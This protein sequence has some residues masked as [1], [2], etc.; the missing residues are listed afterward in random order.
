MSRHGIT[1]PAIVL[2]LALTATFAISCRASE[3]LQRGDYNEF[4]NGRD[5]DCREGLIC[6]EGVC[7]AGGPAADFSCEEICQ[8]MTDCD[9]GTPTCV[10]DCLTTMGSWSLQAKNEFAHCAVEDLSCAEAQE[11]FAQ[12]CYS[13]I[14][15]PD[16]RENT[17]DFFTETANNCSPGVNTESLGQACYKL[18]RTGTD[19]AW[20]ATQQCDNAINTGLCS[21]LATCFNDVF[22]LNPGISLGYDFIVLNNFENNA[23]N[24]ISDAGTP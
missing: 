18:A 1:F 16:G 15:I 2:F 19:A 12:I 20:A 5:D 8:R 17:C 3:E 24:T 14:V 10:V 21:G 23:N 13:R 7:T 6:E 11:D 4:C 9:A 22:N